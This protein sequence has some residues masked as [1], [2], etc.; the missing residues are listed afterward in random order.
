MSN[1][2]RDFERQLREIKI[3]PRFILRAVGGVIIVAVVLVFLTTSWVSIGPEEKGVVLRFGKYNRTLDPGL[4]FKIPWGVDVV[5]KVPVQ[6][7]L[8]EEFGFRTT[9]A[10][11]NTLYSDK[12]YDEES[13]MLTG[14]LNVADIEWVTQFRITEPLLWLFRVKDVKDTF[15]D[16]NE[17]VMREAIGDRSINEVL[18]IGRNEIELLVKEQ[19]NQLCKQYELGLTVNEV[20]LQDVNPP[21]QVKPAFNAV[22]Q[23]QQEK[24][25]LIN[26][27]RQA[28][29]KVVPRAAGDAERMLEEAQGYAIERTNHA[30]GEAGRFN[31][32]FTEYIKAPEVTRQRIYLETMGKVIDQ[33]GRKI[34]IDEKASGILP[35]LNLNPESK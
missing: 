14:D 21:E 15:R 19:L 27:A 7:Q 11:V 31:S 16:I 13:L 29:N 1:F 10:D 22:N 6:N 23:A 5:S 12:G 33:V 26:Q 4:H 28:Y 8:K 20:I 30:K 34:I 24:E 35:L 18:T 9:R 3:D 2:P 32:V 17:A 25:T